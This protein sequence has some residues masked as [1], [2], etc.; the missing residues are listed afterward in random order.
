MIESTQMTP[1]LALFG[2][3]SRRQTMTDRTTKTCLE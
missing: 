1:E 2:G 3:A